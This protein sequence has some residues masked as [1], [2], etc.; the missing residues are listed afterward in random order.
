MS[1][2]RNRTPSADLEQPCRRGRIRRHAGEPEPVDRSPQQ[3]R[4]ADRVGRR[5]EQQAPTLFGGSASSCRVKLELD[6]IR[7][8]HRRRPTEAARELAGVRPRGSSSSA[9]GLPR[10]SATMRS[11]SRTSSGPRIAEA[12]SVRASASPSPPTSRFAEDPRGPA[13]RVG[14]RTAKTMPT[15]SASR[16]RATKARVCADARSCHWASSIT[17]RSGRSSATSERRL[18]T[19]RPTRKRSGASSPTVRPSAAP[20]A[21]RCGS[22]SRSRRSSIGAHS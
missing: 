8:R 1:G 9:S 16:R 17:Q 2:C 10:A 4:V 12:S 13:R 20:S 11:R 5:H 6:A 3:R 15:G 14:S 22:G 21:S 18:S 7:Q 19:A